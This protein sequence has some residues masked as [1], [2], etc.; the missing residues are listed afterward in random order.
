MKALH[1]SIRPIGNSLGV[2][3]P[4]PL[5]AQVSDKLIMGEFGN[6]ADTDLVW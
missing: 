4:K 5:L 2:V 1:V 3:I 6:E